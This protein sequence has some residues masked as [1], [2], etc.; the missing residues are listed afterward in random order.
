MHEPSLKASTV[1]IGVKGWPCTYFCNK[2]VFSEDRI[3]QLILW[4]T[5]LVIEWPLLL[6]QHGDGLEIT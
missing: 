3:F 5:E 4:A 6:V 2:G 1:M